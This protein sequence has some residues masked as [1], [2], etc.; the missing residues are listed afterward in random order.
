[1]TNLL[2]RKDRMSMYSAVEVRVPFADHRIL[3]YV[4]NVPW[5][6]KF[7]GGTEKALLRRA[8]AGALADYILHRK[9]SPYPKTHNP[10]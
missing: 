2:S 3:E 1:M 4:F 8:M 9:K 6:I 7:E 10:A 5:A